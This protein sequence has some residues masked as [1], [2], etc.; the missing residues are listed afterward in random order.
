MNIKLYTKKYQLNK[1][2]LI[3]WPDLAQYLHESLHL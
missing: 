3:K 2:K 1:D